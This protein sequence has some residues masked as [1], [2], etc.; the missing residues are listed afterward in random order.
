MNRW[1]I[2]SLLIGFFIVIVAELIYLFFVAGLVN[3]SVLHVNY[4]SSASQ[5]PTCFIKGVDCKTGQEINFDG[6]FYGVGF[7]AKP[8]SQ[9]VSVYNGGLTVGSLNIRDRENNKIQR[10]QIINLKSLDK[11]DLP[12]IVYLLS[13]PTNLQPQAVDTN[14]FLTVLGKTGMPPF[15]DF[16]LIVQA[17]DKENNLINPLVIFE[18]L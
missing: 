4:D 5:K 17:Y 10:Y 13:E 2:V 9:L 6:R 3:R 14:Q 1:I 12:Q 7:R 8:D 18:R 16:N 11:P 15:G